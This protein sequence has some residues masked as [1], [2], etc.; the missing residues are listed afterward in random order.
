MAECST[1]LPTCPH[2]VKQSEPSSVGTQC[3]ALHRHPTYSRSGRHLP[4]E[5]CWPPRSG[6]CASTAT[7]PGRT[8]RGCINRSLCTL[9]VAARHPQ[10]TMHNRSGLRQ[11]ER[12]WC[13][14]DRHLWQLRSGCCASTSPGRIARG[15]RSSRSWTPTRW[16]GAWDSGGR[17]YRHTR[18][19]DGGT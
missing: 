13:P 3:A 7:P 15:S 9:R 6:R 11:L 8:A 18:L 14:L 2:Y 12:A 16:L 19:A 17:Q 5:D 4:E 1:M 10:P